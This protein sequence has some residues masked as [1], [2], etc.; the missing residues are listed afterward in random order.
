M[1][2]SGKDGVF[3]I[4]P[5]DDTAEALQ[6]FQSL[7][8]EAIA[9]SGDG[10]RAKEHVTL[11]RGLPGVRSVYDCVAIFPTASARRL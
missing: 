1:T 9:N 3:D 11:E 7:A 10:Y 6:A 8:R 4:V 2:R 5:V